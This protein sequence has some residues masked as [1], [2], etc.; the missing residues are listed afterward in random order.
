MSVIIISERTTFCLLRFSVNDN[1]MRIETAKWLGYYIVAG[2][3][4][5]FH[6]EPN[7]ADRVKYRVAG[8]T[9][10]YDFVHAFNSFI[11]YNTTYLFL[12]TV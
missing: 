5:L 9:V 3:Y 1:I 12:K 4:V 7:S 10:V 6:G 2:R 11:T 8:I